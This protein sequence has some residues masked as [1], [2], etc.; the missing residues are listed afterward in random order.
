MCEQECRLY[1]SITVHNLVFELPFKIAHSQIRILLLNV[2]TFLK[3]REPGIGGKGGNCYFVHHLFP[4]LL[5]VNWTVLHLIFGHWLFPSQQHLLIWL[6]SIHGLGRRADEDS[7][8]SSMF[9]PLPP[10]QVSWPFSSH[11]WSFL[12]ATLSPFFWPLY[13]KGR[14]GSN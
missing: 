1:F 4:L 12:L 6:R 2:T 10:S 3:G 5:P 8:T 7:P 13:P 9:Q 14:K 11:F